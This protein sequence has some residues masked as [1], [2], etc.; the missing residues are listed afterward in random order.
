MVGTFHFIFDVMEMGIRQGTAPQL[1]MHQP[2]TKH[3]NQEVISE[4][5]GAHSAWG[6]EEVQSS[7]WERGD[8]RKQLEFRVGLGGIAQR[9]M[10]VSRVSVAVLVSGTQLCS[11]QL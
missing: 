2:A 7:P 6:W 9:T 4:E 1:R 3:C 10:A 5:G 11:C 8:G